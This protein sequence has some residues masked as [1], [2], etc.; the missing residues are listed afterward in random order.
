MNNETGPL[1]RLIVLMMKCWFSDWVIGLSG[2]SSKVFAVDV[3]ARILE[4]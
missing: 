2:H 1:I 3:G 4:S